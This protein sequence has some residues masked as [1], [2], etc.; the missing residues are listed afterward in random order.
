MLRVGVDIGGTFT[1]VTIL[2]NLVANP[3]GQDSDYAQGPVNRG[4]ERVEVDGDSTS[5]RSAPVH[6]TVA[7]NALIE[8][9]GARTGLITT[10]PEDVLKSAGNRTVFFD[11][12]YQRPTPLSAPRCMGVGACQRSGRCRRASLTPK[13]SRP[14]STALHLK[15]SSQSQSVSC[16]LSRILLTRGR[17]E[18]WSARNTLT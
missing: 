14:S 12:F 6:G 8:N 11:I 13:R 16:T 9:K 17:S 10:A 1:D 5:R 3:F 15:V 4:L 7:I 2:M 18:T